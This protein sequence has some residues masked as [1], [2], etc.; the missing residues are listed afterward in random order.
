MNRYRQIPKEERAHFNVIDNEDSDYYQETFECFL[1][2]ANIMMTD[3]DIE[4]GEED[5]FKA[6]IAHSRGWYFAVTGNDKVFGGVVFLDEWVGNPI[7]KKPHSCNINGYSNRK[8]A[9][10]SFIAVDAMLY[11]LFNI[12]GLERVGARI[13]A[14]NRPARKLAIRHEFKPE[15]IE[16]S[17][18]L[19]DGQI[20]D[21]CT[22]SIIKA[23]YGGKLHGR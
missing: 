3:W 23:E 14:T 4:A 9:Y 8:D 17:G 12:V 18:A 6:H 2:N 22:Y 7:T 20:I 1:D 13:L 21:V 10:R 15:G 5:T 11:Y 16:R 19:K